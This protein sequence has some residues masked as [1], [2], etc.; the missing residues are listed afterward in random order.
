MQLILI[1][2]LSG[3]GKTV[4]LRTLEDA[5]FDAIDNLPLSLL[6]AVS[7]E[8]VAVGADIRARDFS[9]RHLEEALSA[10]RARGD[11]SLSIVYLDSDDAVLQRRFTET[12]RR[13][14]LAHDRPVADGIR[15]ER[16]LLEGIRPMANI[17]LDTSDMEAA[18]LR[19]VIGGHFADSARDLSV[20]VTSFSY[21][22]GLP[23]EADLVFDVRFLRN[24]HYDP[25]LTSLTG[26]EAA[27]GAHI[28]EDTA[29]A[30][31]FERL[32]A[33]V[34]PL[35][36]RYREEGKHYLT[37]A[38]GCTGGRHRSVF[39]AERLAERI[40]SAGFPVQVRHREV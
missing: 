9:V 15:H 8:R 26:R 6:P 25:A 30:P 31:F 11:V 34:L 4:A 1:T 16:A 7:G 36:P 13:H 17:V 39:V 14:P 12:R 35:L 38:V 27:V 23:R 19:R 18:D 2:G 33:L 22:R 37:V 29:Y 32:C 5:G 40:A 10:L 20:T 24:P 3:A 28:M 21:K